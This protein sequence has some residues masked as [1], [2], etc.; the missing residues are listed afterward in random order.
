MPFAC[1]AWFKIKHLVFPSKL[2]TFCFLGLEFTGLTRIPTPY[3]VY[4]IDTGK[5]GR[6]RDSRPPQP[7]PPV[8]LFLTGGRDESR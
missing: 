3:R 5:E 6:A 1:K 7:H 8:D 2:W 4:L